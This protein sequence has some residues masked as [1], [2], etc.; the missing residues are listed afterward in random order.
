MVNNSLVI[1]QAHLGREKPTNA[2]FEVCAQKIVH[3]VPEL[4]DPDPPVRKDAFKTWGTTLVQ[5]K[6]SYYNRKIVE[7]PRKRKQINEELEI[8]SAQESHLQQLQKE[9]KASKPDRKKIEALMVAYF[10]KRR[11][12]IHSLK[13]K[14]TVKKIL[15]EYPGFKCYDQEIYTSY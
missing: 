9:M 14:G 15:G 6:K 2:E 3:L 13:G 11:E 7:K 4:N 8:D 5:L 1:L 10:A 12:W